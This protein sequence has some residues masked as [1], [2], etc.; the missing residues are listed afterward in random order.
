MPR[1]EILFEENLRVLMHS[2]STSESFTE[3]EYEK[4]HSE[5]MKKGSPV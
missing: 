4:H 2:K 1:Q 3:K 5:L